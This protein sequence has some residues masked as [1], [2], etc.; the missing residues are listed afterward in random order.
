MGLRE[1]EAGPLPA[2]P[3]ATGWAAPQTSEPSSVSFHHKAPLNGF[4]PVIRAASSK[5]LG[6]VQGG[7]RRPGPAEAAG[8]V[9]CWV[10]L[11][12]KEN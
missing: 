9:R 5:D 2:L 8:R 10:C 7:P 6:S 4:P 12:R 3:G 1:Q 11:F